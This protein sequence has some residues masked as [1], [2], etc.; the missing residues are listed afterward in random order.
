MASITFT[1]GMTSITLSCLVYPEQPKEDLPQVRSQNAVG[2]VWTMDMASGYLHDPEIALELTDA[3][4]DDLRNFIVN[5]VGGSINEFTYTDYDSNDFTV[6]YMGGLREMQRS[7]NNT[8][9]ARIQLH[10]VGTATP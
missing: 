9:I 8:W 3:H 6:Q 10:V 5:T 7:G 2:D 1:Y 4:K